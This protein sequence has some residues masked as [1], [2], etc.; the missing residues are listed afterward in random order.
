MYVVSGGSACQEQLI[1]AA[2]DVAHS[3]EGIVEAAQQSCRD[4]KLLADLAAA[5]TAVTQALNDLLQH[6]KKGAGPTAAGESHEDAVDMILTV[7]DRL[8]SSVGDAH[9]MVRQARQLAQRPLHRLGPSGEKP[10]AT[11][12]RTCRNGSW[13]PP[14]NSLMLQRTWWKL[15]RAVRRVRTTQ[16]SRRD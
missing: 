5:A 1:D 15:P 3:V 11:L 9:E 6:I 12:T 13:P 16:S 2:K 10:R 14:D 8:F 7:T 4:D